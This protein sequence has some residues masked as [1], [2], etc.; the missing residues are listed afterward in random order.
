MLKVVD[1][2]ADSAQSRVRLEPKKKS[3]M[4]FPY[5]YATTERVSPSCLENA[6][7]ELEEVKGE[8]QASILRQEISSGRKE[9]VSRGREVCSAEALKRRPIN[10][11]DPNRKKNIARPIKKNGKETA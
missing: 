2:R 5:P 3:T 10:K 6:G 1:R 9:P 8:S 11:R 4:G 7:R